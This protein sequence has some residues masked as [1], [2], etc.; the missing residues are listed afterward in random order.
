MKQKKKPH[1]CNESSQDTHSYS[2]LLSRKEASSN[3]AVIKTVIS[4]D[5]DY[6]HLK[7]DELRGKNTNLQI[8]THYYKIQFNFKSL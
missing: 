1:W 7:C 4:F 3:N 5:L 2:I 6:R 8:L